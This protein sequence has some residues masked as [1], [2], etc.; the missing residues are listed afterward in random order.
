MTEQDAIRVFDGLRK[1]YRAIDVQQRV[2]AQNVLT[3]THIISSPLAHSFTSALGSL[4]AVF[5]AID[6]WEASN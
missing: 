6:R 5:D 4:R 3:R 2:E 1:A